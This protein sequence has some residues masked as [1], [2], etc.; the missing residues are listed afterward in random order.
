M[1][2]LILEDAPGMFSALQI[3]GHASCM[4]KLRRKKQNSSYSRR[5]M[6]FRGL[7]C[8]RAQNRLYFAKSLPQSKIVRRT[9][10]ANPP[11]L[12]SPVYQRSLLDALNRHDEVFAFTMRQAK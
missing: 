1:S 7:D 9:T 5:E 10:L 2:K 12:L 11:H 6:C 4:N 8:N 3:P